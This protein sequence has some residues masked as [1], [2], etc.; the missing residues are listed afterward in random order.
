MSFNFTQLAADPLNGANQNPLNPATWTIATGSSALQI[1]GNVCKG[2]IL[3]LDN[4]ELYTGISWPNDQYG[5]VKII[6][7]T[8]DGENVD[9]LLRSNA[10]AS[11]CYFCG[12]GLNISDGTV[13]VYC[14]RFISNVDIVLFDVSEIPFNSGDV[15][16]FAVV[17]TTVLA[18]RNGTLVTSAVNSDIASGAVGVDIE[19]NQVNNVSFTNFAGGTVSS[20]SSTAYSVPD[21]RISTCGL[22]PTTHVYPNGNRTVQGTKIYD[23]ETSNNP[24]IPPVDSRKAGAPVDCRVSPNIPQNSRTPGTFGPGE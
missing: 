3:G 15:F 19:T 2:T 9:V 17:G 18:Y 16:R 6:S 20:S 10:D 12:V 8:D 7:L 22:V 14:Q 4:I 24:A 21:C 23:V 5:E 1:L 11:T 13:Q